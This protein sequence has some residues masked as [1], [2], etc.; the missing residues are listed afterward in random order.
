[1]LQAKGRPH[2]KKAISLG[3]GSLGASKDQSRRMK[4]LV[5]FMAIV[6]N[7]QRATEGH[8]SLPLY[9][10]D[11]TFDK[12]DEEFLRMLGIQ[13]L[14]TPSPSDLG[15][16]GDMIDGETLIY[17]PFL[18]IS[19]YGSL[20]LPGISSSPGTETIAPIL[21]GDD[22]NALKLKWEKKT[23]EH[24]DVEVLTK[25]IRENNYQ[26]RAIRGEGFWLES[27]SPFPMALYWRRPNEGSKSSTI[28]PNK[29]RSRPF[30]GKL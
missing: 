1:M 18:T 5:I 2:V 19:A 28:T 30:K 21:I 22:F 3:L 6:S 20:L 16:A 8:P 10:Q 12:T 24:K 23:Q 17:S 26:R 4:Q 15:Q 11:P 9:A 14:N 27:D 7:L 29:P 25:S 13:V